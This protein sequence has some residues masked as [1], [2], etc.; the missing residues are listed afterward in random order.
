MQNY[1][2][3]NARIVNE[4]QV[5]EGDVYVSNGRI[6]KI[7]SGLQAPGGVV[8]IDAEGK[9]LLPGV[10]DDQVHFREPGLTQCRG[11]RLC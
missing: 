11:D 9:Y 5:V 7:G 1:L 10:I 2:I 6:E 8:E 3:R 4:G